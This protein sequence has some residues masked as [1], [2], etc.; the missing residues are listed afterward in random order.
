MRF[1]YM[2]S[3][4][5]RAR[6]YAQPPLYRMRARM[7]VLCVVALLEAAFEGGCVVSLC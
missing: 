4:A 6:A 1:L 7:F 3:S 2:S 5:S